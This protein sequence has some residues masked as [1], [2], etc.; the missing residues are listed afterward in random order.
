MIDMSSVRENRPTERS[1]AGSAV[2]LSTSK[3]DIPESEMKSE[4][5]EMGTLQEE[6]G[7]KKNGRSFRALI[8]GE[9]LVNFASINKV[10]LNAL[11]RA[12]PY[13]IGIVSTTEKRN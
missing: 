10:L 4:K 8:G 5:N 12:N 13:N 9:K 7:S 11:L 6:I 2:A 1:M 3:N